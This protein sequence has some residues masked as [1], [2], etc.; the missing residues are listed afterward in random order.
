MISLLEA[1]EEAGASVELMSHALGKVAPN[2][3]GF[4]DEGNT[5]EEAWYA[6]RAL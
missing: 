2:F 4:D 1:T 6:V 3:V 5:P